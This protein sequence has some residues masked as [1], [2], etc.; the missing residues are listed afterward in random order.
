MCTGWRFKATSKTFRRAYR[1]LKDGSSIEDLLE[2][3]ERLGEG[4][5]DS[6]DDDDEDEKT[7]N[8]TKVVKGGVGGKVEK[9]RDQVKAKE[10]SEDGDDDDDDC[11][12][13]AEEDDMLNLYNEFR[14]ADS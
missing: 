9:D 14:E 2:H 3:L 4:L 1:T 7:K 10:Q 6:E 11:E 12:D 5:M 13:V 8:K